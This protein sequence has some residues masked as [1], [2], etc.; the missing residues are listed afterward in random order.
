MTYLADNVM[1]PL[2]YKAQVV[3]LHVSVQNINNHVTTVF[4]ST[5]AKSKTPNCANYNVLALGTCKD[6]IIEICSNIYLCSA[7]DIYIR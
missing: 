7:F 5:L 3:T 2:K 1:H 6:V 4:T